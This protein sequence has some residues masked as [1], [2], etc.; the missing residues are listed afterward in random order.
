[1][2]PL[3]ETTVMPTEV[4]P[5]IM[6]MAVIILLQLSQ[7]FFAWRK[8]MRQN[9]QVRKEDLTALRNEI[10]DEI[11]D[12][13]GDVADLRKSVEGKMEVARVES[14]KARTEIHNRI[15]ETALKTSALIAGQETLNQNLIA[16][17]NRFNMTHSRKA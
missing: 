10:M 16:L 4:T 6:G 2:M 8:D 9:D 7:F 5:A 12:I 3:A 1:M 11:D 17:N 15:T 14:S 13:S